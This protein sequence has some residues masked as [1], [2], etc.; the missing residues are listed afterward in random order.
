MIHIYYF[1]RYREH[2]GM[3]AEDF[4]YSSQLQNIQ[5]LREVLI[6]RGGKWKI[7]EEERLMCARNKELCSNNEP[8][9]DGDQI[10]FFPQVTGG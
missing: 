6:A 4:A 8:I 3:D 1:A 7:L 2:L 5:V 10:A 9:I